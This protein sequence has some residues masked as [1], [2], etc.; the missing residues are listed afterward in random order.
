MRAAALLPSFGN[1]D[2]G[3]DPVRSLFLVGY[4]Q[5]GTAFSGEALNGPFRARNLSFV[6]IRERHFWRVC[7]FL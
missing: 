3:R 7:R 2:S 5:H 4:L 6:V 1:L